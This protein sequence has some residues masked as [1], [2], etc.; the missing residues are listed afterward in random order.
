MMLRIRK[1]TPTYYDGG[2][3]VVDDVGPCVVILH[4]QLDEE[5]APPAAAT[6]CSWTS[7][8]AE[9]WDGAH[10]NWIDIDD[11]TDVNEP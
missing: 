7:I 2:F 6:P 9:P 1:C 5:I 3:E 11:P 10:A 4:W 8:G